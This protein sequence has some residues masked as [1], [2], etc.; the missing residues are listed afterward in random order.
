M[1]INHL[2]RPRAWSAV[3]ELTDSEIRLRLA[4]EAAELAAW[5]WDIQHNVVEWSQELADRHGLPL[6]SAPCTVEEFAAHLHPGDVERVRATIEHSLATD[7]R[8]ECQF[9]FLRPDGSERWVLSMGKIV[10]DGE[11]VPIRMIGVELDITERHRLQMEQEERERRLT[12]ALE[13]GQMGIWDYFPAEHRLVWDERQQEIWGCSL[14]DE[15]GNAEAVLG[16]VHPEDAPRVMESVQAVASR[17]RDRFDESFRLP[18]PD[19]SVRWLRGIGT[20]CDGRVIG[21]NYDIS[22]SRRI[23]E[24]RRAYA[25]RMR[26]AQEVA[27]VGTFEWNVTTGQII[28]TS[29]LEA[30]YG[31]PPGSFG[32]GYEA[33]SAMVHPEDLPFVEADIQRS[34]ENGTFESVWRIRR[35]EG[36]VRWISGRGFVFHNGE[37][38]PVQMVGVNLDVTA[39]R[40]A[41]LALQA[42]EELFRV[43]ADVIPQ[44][45]VLCEPTGEPIW[46]NTAFRQYFKSEP[47]SLSAVHAFAHP[48]DRE[49]FNVEWQRAFEAGDPIEFKCRLRS[50]A[51]EY[52]WF[53]THLSPIKDPNR[54]SGQWAGSFSDIHD[55]VVLSDALYERE[56]QY[57]QIAESL[58]QLVWSNR[59]DGYPDYFNARWCEYT[60]MSTDAQGWDW[61]QY[62]HPEDLELT[63]QAWNHSLQ[64]GSDY[65]VEYRFRRASDG[66]YRWFLGLAKP[67]RNQAGEIIRWFG[68]LTDIQTQKEM[69]AELESRVMTRTTELARASAELE[70]LLYTIAHDLRSPLRSIVATSRIL[71]REL[72]EVLNAEQQLR[73][74]RQEDNA[75]RLARQLDDM[76]RYARLGRRPLD[77]RLV[78]VSELAEQIAGRVVASYEDRTLLVEVQPGMSLMADPED[79]RHLLADLLDNAAKYSPQGGTIRV[80]FE[81][82]SVYVSDEGIG[83]DTSYL[84][85]MLQPFQRLHRNEEFPGTGI[86]LAIVAL[87]AERHGGSVQA[88]SGEAGSIFRISLPLDRPSERVDG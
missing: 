54:A 25:E 38:R 43:T 24:Q 30:L 76:L 48:E 33:W 19:G 39:A 31:M 66:A 15:P 59:P 17:Q 68:S 71:G 7:S 41:E 80:G 42:S 32:G 64:T 86:G 4:L 5:E 1:H 82:A 57:R 79:M 12:L 37:G 11:N 8:F 20:L 27:K 46:A 75:L 62:L 16:L 69:E 55:H 51:G 35:P 53:R 18:Q 6:E 83:F 87:V 77:V 23:E 44:H 50:H 9:R 81:G 88:E 26:I 21:L 36:D 34:L 28:W 2:G 49:F 29:E 61:V 74:E 72:T 22:E 73:L 67:I 60:G 65:V 70:S 3:G 40:E 14:P 13:G 84:P 52:R 56:S 58:P 45:L 47:I 85:K 78:H 63:L 10:R